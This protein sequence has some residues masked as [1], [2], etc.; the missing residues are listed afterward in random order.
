MIWI[1]GG[2]F[3]VPENYIKWYHKEWITDCCDDCDVDLYILPVEQK[4]SLGSARQEDKSMLNTRNL[5]YICVCQLS[6]V[7]A[8][9]W[10]SGRHK[11][12]YSFISIQLIH[13]IICLTLRFL[14]CIRIFL[15]LTCLR[16]LPKGKSTKWQFRCVVRISQL[17]NEIQGTSNVHQ[18]WQS[19]F[20]LLLLKQEIFCLSPLVAFLFDERR[21]TRRLVQIVFLSGTMILL[22]FLVVCLEICFIFVNICLKP[23]L[24]SHKTLLYLLI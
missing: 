12:C 14:L 17:F 7:Y 3:L 10:F 22:G 24:N 6:V 13:K 16:S 18:V 9:E 15:Y 2:Q 5:F 20:I 8:S 4:K 11:I 21:K 23:L 1:K 19:P